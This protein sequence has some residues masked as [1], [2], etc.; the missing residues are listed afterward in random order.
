[1][2]INE[3]VDSTGLTG[4]MVPV[5]VRPNDLDV[6]GHVNNAVALEYFEVGRWDWFARLGLALASDRAVAPVVARLEIDYL[7]QITQK[8]VEVTTQLVSPDKPDINAARVFRALL[9]QDIRIP[10]L[11][12]PAVR[13]LVTIAFVD[14]QQNGRLISLHEFLDRAASMRER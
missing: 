14:Q 1:M 2:R 9:R 8:Q 7:T 10:D 5:Q 3:W 4:S 6:Q 13:A 11:A 12:R